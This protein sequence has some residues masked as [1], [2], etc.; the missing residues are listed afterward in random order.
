MESNPLK[1]SDGC[2]SGSTSITQMPDRA[3]TQT[4][5]ATTKV[6][7][8]LF[9]PSQIFQSLNQHVI[10][11]EKVKLTMSVGVHN[12]YKRI[13]AVDEGSIVHGDVCEESMKGRLL[14]EY[15]GVMLDKSN[16]LLVG[17]TGSGKT[18]LA[19]TLAS[20][21]DVPF[22]MAD[23]T[24]LTEAGY[25]GQGELEPADAIYLSTLVLTSPSTCSTRSLSL[26]VF[27]FINTNVPASTHLRP[28]H[29]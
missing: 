20:L 26:H 22:V 16:M 21:V 28:L 7:A 6:K 13:S 14:K 18:L 24:C 2:E 15:S 3:P 12:H 5:A 23:A 4:P 10:G 17:P 25:V 29:F 19:K 1:E 8:K 11:Q 9:T 27:H